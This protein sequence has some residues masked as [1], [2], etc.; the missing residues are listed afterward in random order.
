MLRGNVAAAQ[1]DEKGDDD[2]VDEVVA[3]AA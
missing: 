1:G 2:E 3:E